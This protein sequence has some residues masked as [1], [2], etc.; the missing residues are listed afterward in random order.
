MSGPGARRGRA[1]KVESRYSPHHRRLRAAVEWITRSLGDAPLGCVIRHHGTTVG[2]E[3]CR[4]MTADILFEIGSIRKSFNSALIGCTSD[5]SD[6]TIHLKATNMWPELVAI[7]GDPGDTEIT[8]HHLAS[9]VSGWMTP[10]PP[11]L[12]FLY[13]SA[14]ST[15]AERVVGRY[16]GFPHDEIAA[17]IARRFKEP[18][19]AASWKIYHFPGQFTPGDVENPGPKLAIDSDLAD[20]ATWGE[21]WCNSGRWRGQQLI[22]E[23]YVKRATSLVNPDIPSSHYGYGWFVNA[24]HALWPRVPADSYGHAGF[25]SFRSSGEPSRAFLWVCPSLSVVAAI[26]TDASAGFAGDF[27]DVPNDFT[28]EC[29]TKIMS[30]L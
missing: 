13:N 12:R 28:A 17:E 25:G 7:S 2:H 26:I 19:D 5:R 9:G 29:I 16:W 11:G 27:L 20:L 24:G 18:L 10:D 22:P 4:G 6:F 30:A 14:A 21:L 8:L 23:A 3:V 1:V 15:A